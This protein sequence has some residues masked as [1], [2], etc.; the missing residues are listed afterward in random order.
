MCIHILTLPSEC[1]RR[2][3]LGGL[4]YVHLSQLTLH[5][6]YGLLDWLYLHR[7][8]DTVEGAVALDTN[9]LCVRRWR[10]G[11]RREGGVRLQGVRTTPTT[12]N[13]ATTSASPP[14]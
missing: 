8:S 3:F 6:R 13:Y 12:P 7:S 5:L 4:G 9:V 14:I 11:G 2:L 1:G 10:E